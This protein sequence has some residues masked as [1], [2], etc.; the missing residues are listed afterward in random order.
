MGFLF[1]CFRHHRCS[2]CCCC[3]IFRHIWIGHHFFSFL[4]GNR[5]KHY[6]FLSNQTKSKKKI[7]NQKSNYMIVAVKWWFVYYAYYH[8]QHNQHQHNHRLISCQAMKNYQGKKHL[9]CSANQSINRSI[10]NQKI[11]DNQK[12]NKIQPTIQN[13]N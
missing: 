13:K 2:C 1:V 3:R 12:N 10:I 11:V 8:H 4:I 6:I 9:Y 5:S 7:K